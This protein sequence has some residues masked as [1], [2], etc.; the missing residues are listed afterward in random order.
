MAYMH[1]GSFVLNMAV[2]GSLF[3]CTL[4]RAFL[5]QQL[6]AAQALS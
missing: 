6:Q 5:Y 1:H 4:C 2:G 3:C